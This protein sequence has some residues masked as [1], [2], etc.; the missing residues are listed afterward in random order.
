MCPTT[1][2]VDSKTPTYDLSPIQV[3]LVWSGLEL[4]EKVNRGDNPLTQIHTEKDNPLT[5]IHIEMGVK[6]TNTL[7][8]FVCVYVC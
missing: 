8:V 6:A 4:F 7:C 3:W 1:C 5:Q 2:V